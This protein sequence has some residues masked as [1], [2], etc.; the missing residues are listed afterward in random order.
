MKNISLIFTFGLASPL[1]GWIGCVGLLC[2]WL[3]LF[4]LAERFE[5]KTKGEEVKT[6]AEGIPFRCIV[7]VVFCN[8]G[9][10]GTA[11]ILA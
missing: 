8:I 4:F 6:D 2:R 11:A 9:F 3:A 5:E 1:V 10:F 7:L